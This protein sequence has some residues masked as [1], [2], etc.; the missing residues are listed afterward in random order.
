[1]RAREWGTWKGLERENRR[2]NDIIILQSQKL[3]IIDKT[4]FI[5][6]IHPKLCSLGKLLEYEIFFFKNKINTY[7]NRPVVK[8]T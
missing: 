7:V 1:M 8:I 3:K 5:I 4:E 2:E 6:L